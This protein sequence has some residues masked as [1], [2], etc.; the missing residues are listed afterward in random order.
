ML[1]RQP[2]PRPDRKYKPHGRIIRHVAYQFDSIAV[3]VGGEE[4]TKGCVS[5][6]GQDHV[7]AVVLKKCSDMLK[8]STVFNVHEVFFSL[9]HILYKA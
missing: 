8:Q 3:G 2:S 7:Q 9:I 4:G 6:E 5:I 1:L